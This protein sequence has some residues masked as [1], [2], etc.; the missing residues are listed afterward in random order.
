MC[1]SKE[2]EPD[3]KIA[4]V[5]CAAL[6]AAPVFADDLVARNGDDSVRLTE[7]ACTSQ[8]VL[9]RLDPQL[10]SEYKAASAMVGG[11]SFQA[12]WHVVGNSAH[13]MYEDGDQGLIPLSDLKPELSA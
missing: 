13:L 11:H 9:A 5:L 12:C 10:Q 8:P 3:M 1:S 4:I 7:A 6:V 2:L